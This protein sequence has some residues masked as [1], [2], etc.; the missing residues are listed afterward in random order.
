MSSRKIGPQSIT[1]TKW[2][3][4]IHP[5]LSLCCVIKN[6]FV[7]VCVNEELNLYLQLIL[8]DIER[9]IMEPQV[10]VSCQEPTTVII[11]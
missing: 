5:I 10:F 3:F 6:I 1:D 11:L 9:V 7:D 4:I 8:T 2:Q